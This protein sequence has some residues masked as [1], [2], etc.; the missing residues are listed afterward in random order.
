MRY[1]SILNK[2][3][4][5]TILIDE[6]VQCQE[7]WMWGLFRKE[8]KNIYMAGDHHQ[9]SSI[10]SKDGIKLNHNRSL[11]ERLIN[12][13]YPTEFLKVQRRMHPDIVE[14]SNETFYEGKLETDYKEN[15]IDL[16]AFEIINVDGDEERIGTSYQNL[17][18]AKKVIEL[19]D[20]INIKNTIVISPYQAQCKLLRSLKKNIIVH[21]VDSFQGQEADC[22]ILTTVRSENNIG[23]WN[24]YRRLN[25]GL[26]RAKN[27]LRIVGKLET[28]KSNEGPLKK[29]LEFY[30][31]KNL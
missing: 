7:A 31:K 3:R 13:G 19:I 25:V 9:L 18:E 27:I 28:W 16:K 17:L 22:V 10:V 15:N 12:L 6:A 26:T 14:F 21:T 23:F 24:N 20:K 5:K 1:S 8:V 29:L 4:F 11:M 30:Q 2:K